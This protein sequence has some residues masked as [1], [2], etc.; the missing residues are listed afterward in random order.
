MK[1]KSVE[2][3]NILDKV[4]DGIMRE[5]IDRSVIDAAAERVWAR[6]ST[7]LS[8]ESAPSEIQSSTV[9]EI[10]GCSDFQS[11][12]P[13]YLKGELSG[14]RALLLEDHTQECIPCRKAMKAAR[15]GVRVE[16]KPARVAEIKRSTTTI[17]PV[18]KWAIAATLVLSLGLGF[19]AFL[20][21]FFGTGNGRGTI[22]AVNGSAYRVTDSQL[23]L[24]KPGDV[25][26]RGERI[27]TARDS[28]AVVTLND[29]SQV[30]MRER[31]E[32]FVSENSS[33]TTVNLAR[34]N[35][36]I[37]AAKQKDGRHL[38]VATNDSLTSVVGT[39]FS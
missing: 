27:R 21:R 3:E 8:A 39:V 30:E 20:Q 28:N 4:T 19:F 22:Q 36:I 17:T 33:G 29:G 12:I 23:A 5:E 9:E 37:E 31:S 32:F 24:L 1:R 14:A 7:E 35:V 18:W 2:L 6:L 15:S 13:A 25:I 11:L 26:S 16:A 10:R 38:Y 34:G